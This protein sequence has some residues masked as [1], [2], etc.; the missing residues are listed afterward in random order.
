MFGILSKPIK[1]R[2]TIVT[3]KIM[4]TVSCSMTAH[5]AG[6]QRTLQSN[7]L[8]NHATV[9]KLYTCLLNFNMNF[10]LIYCLFKVQ[11]FAS[12]IGSGRDDFSEPDCL[13]M[14]SE[15]LPSRLC[16]HLSLLQMGGRTIPFPHTTQFPVFSQ[17]LSST[18]PFVLAPYYVEIFWLWSRLI[19]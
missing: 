7:S 9:T 18:T 8:E 1:S 19:H 16:L 5:S 3:H 17:S 4:G 11:Y 6:N 13:P 14:Q 12:E 15:S 10:R 2:S